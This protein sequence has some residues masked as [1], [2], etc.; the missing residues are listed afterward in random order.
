[1]GN[2]TGRD[3]HIDKMLTQIAIN[4]RPSNYI[5]DQIAPIVPVAKETDLYPVF[6]RAEARS[7]Q[8]TRRA[9]GTKAKLITRSVSSD[10]YK[11]ENF[12]LGQS[13]VLEDRVNIDPAY[14]AELYS[15]ATQHITGLLMNDWENR[16]IRAV[17]STSNVATGFLPASSWAGAGAN[18][19]DPIS[20]IM[21]MI[22]E[23][24][25]RTGE[26]PNSIL[27][28]WKAWKTFR[29]NYH[30]RNFLF[31]NNNGGGLVTRQRAQELFEVDRFLVAD[32][33]FN[34][35][36][37]AQAEVLTSPFADK[38][39]VYYAPTSPS[40]E[41]PSFMYSFRWAAPGLPNMTVERHPYDTETKS[42]KV[43]VGYYQSEKIVGASYGSLLLGVNSAQGS[44][45]V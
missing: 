1:M 40:R 8:D 4:F 3:L 33:F 18:A 21:Q 45:L 16:V 11:V 22:E 30:A 25:A 41:V 13:I 29:R 5:V 31:G 23:H 10:G 19:G 39:L 7:I 36:N 15:G 9:R 26:A 27:M 43:E 32:A 2:S 12:A 38:V 14:E 6:S 34:T 17:S 28:G 35:A 42:E 37:E 24:Q 20:H 44:G